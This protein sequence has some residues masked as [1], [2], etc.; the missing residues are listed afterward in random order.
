MPR[1]THSQQRRRRREEREQAAQRS[2]LFTPRRALGGLA[3]LI[4]AAAIA[5]AVTSSPRSD[6]PH[7]VTLPTQAATQA[8]TSVPYVSPSPTAT[9]ELAREL[10]TIEYGASIADNQIDEIRVDL[11]SSL[12]DILDEG[13]QELGLPLSTQVSTVYVTEARTLIAPLSGAPD[14][15]LALTVAEEMGSFYTFLSDENFRKPDLLVSFPESSEEFDSISSIYTRLDEVVVDD[16]FEVAIIETA[17]VQYVVEGEFSSSQGNTPFE[18]RRTAQYSAGASGRI[19]EGALD[20][21]GWDVSVDVNPIQWSTGVGSEPA[22]SALS[23]ELLYRLVA[24]VTAQNIEVHLNTVSAD[25]SEFSTI[26]LDWIQREVYFVEAVNQLFL[27]H[28][29]N[30][31]LIPWEPDYTGDRARF[32]NDDFKHV[33][34]RIKELTVPVAVQLYLEDPTQIFDELKNLGND[35]FT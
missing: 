1:E 33:K 15:D 13:I 29:T 10:P 31:G 21:D 23:S 35:Q 32:D 7:I 27:E 30:S 20:S 9:P 19:Y 11:E 14:L 34:D 3:A 8:A 16:T 17:V 12:A 28:Q 4:G 25:L 2:T 18:M 24:P 26:T 5:I 6:E 22:Y